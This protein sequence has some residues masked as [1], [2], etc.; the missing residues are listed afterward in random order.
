MNVFVLLKDEKIKRISISQEIQKQLEDYLKD[1]INQ[2]LIKER[3]DFDG[4]Y[5][6]DNNQ[7][8]SISNY[9]MSPL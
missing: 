5:K 9:N 3:I 1:S 2:F 4:Q 7:I 6:P 8:L